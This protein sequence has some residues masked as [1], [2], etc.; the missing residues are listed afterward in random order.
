M[1]HSKIIQE[2]FNKGI[3]SQKFPGLENKV[4]DNNIY[5]ISFLVDVNR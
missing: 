3:I 1:V 4:Y 2:M 5:R